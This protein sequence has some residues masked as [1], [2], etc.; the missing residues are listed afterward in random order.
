MNPQSHWGELVL[1]MF[2]RADSCEDDS[3]ELSKHL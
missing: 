2:L 3:E 1:E